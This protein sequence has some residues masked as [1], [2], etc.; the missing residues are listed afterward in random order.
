M[1]ELGAALPLP[2]GKSPSFGSSSLS[3]GTLKS[4]GVL[5]YDEEHGVAAL[6]SPGRGWLD[7]NDWTPSAGGSAISPSAYQV[8][9]LAPVPRSTGF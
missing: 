4:P 1:T 8:P 5:C 3:V 6:S 9:R 7:A 2:A